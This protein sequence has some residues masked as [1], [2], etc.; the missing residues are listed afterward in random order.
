MNSEVFLLNINLSVSYFSMNKFFSENETLFIHVQSYIVN[1]FVLLS[2]VGWMKLEY[3]AWNELLEINADSIKSLCKE[4]RFDRLYQWKV[5][6]F[7]KS[8]TRR[9]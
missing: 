1:L 4:L 3:T 5:L 2:T 6:G 8:S 9:V 7:T